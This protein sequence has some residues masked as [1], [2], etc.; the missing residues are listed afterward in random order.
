[1]STW[2]CT[3]P[4]PGGVT[5]QGTVTKTALSSGRWA[6]RPFTQSAVEPFIF[7]FLRRSRRSINKRAG[8]LKR[9]IP[10]RLPLPGPPGAPLS[11]VRLRTPL[12]IKV[13]SKP[14]S[15]VGQSETEGV[16]KTSVFDRWK[17]YLSESGP[18][19]LFQGGRVDK[20]EATPGWAAPV[21]DH[22][23]LHKDSAYDTKNLYGRPIRP[24]W[25]LGSALFAS[26]FQALT[27]R[28]GIP[29]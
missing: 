14:M 25:H 28:A 9:M 16:S 17:H 3:G 5:Q 2:R 18:E 26:G 20:A 7:R 19:C 11:N 10:R 12:A 13:L 29:D 21:L 6:R 8:Y 1:M 15:G 24:S 23:T 27:A 22:A 4:A